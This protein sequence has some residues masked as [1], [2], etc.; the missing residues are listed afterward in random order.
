[1]K[2]NKKLIN[3][4]LAFQK[5]KEG[6]LYCNLIS[7]ENSSRVR[8]EITKLVMEMSQG[9]HVDGGCN[10]LGAF[11]LSSFFGWKLVS[12]EEEDGNRIFRFQKK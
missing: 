11:L 1:M 2:K 7:E 10:C 9:I 5:D 3:M 4:Q 6:K 8:G 12:A